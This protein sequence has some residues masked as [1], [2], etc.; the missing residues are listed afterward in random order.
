LHVISLAQFTVA[1]SRGWAADSVNTR[2]RLNAERDRAFQELALVREE[3]RIKDNRMAHILPHR[4]PFSP[5]TER[6]STHH[7][8]RHRASAPCKMIVSRQAHL[9]K[10]AQRLACFNVVELLR[11]YN[12]NAT[13][14]PSTARADALDN[15]KA[16]PRQTLM[17]QR[18]LASDRTAFSWSPLGPVDRPDLD[19]VAP[20]RV[21]RQGSRRTSGVSS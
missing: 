3:M 2:L 11:R 4:R 15:S 16:V 12:N 6:M 10:L 14:S 5:P 7:H 18:L 21:V 17:R 20:R 9:A 8:R 19:T 13:R 1:Y